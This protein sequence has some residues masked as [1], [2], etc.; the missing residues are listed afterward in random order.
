LIVP[1]ASAAID[2]LLQ[3]A[4]G[5]RIERRIS[6][7]GEQLHAPHS[8]DREIIHALRRRVRD[9]VVVPRRGDAAVSFS[10]ALSLTRHAHTALLPRIWQ[11]RHT[12]SV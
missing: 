10:Q 7:R 1:D 3:T 9:G 6:L 8:I 12:L 2:W 5:H 11:Y 4:A